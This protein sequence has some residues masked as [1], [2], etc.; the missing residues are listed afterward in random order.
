MHIKN[1]I[2]LFIL[3]FPSFSL[4]FHKISNMKN[5][6]FSS[7]KKRFSHRTLSKVIRFGSELFSPLIPSPSTFHEPKGVNPKDIFSSKEKITPQEPKCVNPKDI[8]PRQQEFNPPSVNTATHEEIQ[9]HNNS[10]PEINIASGSAL[11]INPAG[12]IESVKSPY[13]NLGNAFFDVSSSSGS[14]TNSTLSME[15]KKVAALNN[16]PRK[17]Q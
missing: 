1:S 10:A 4:S 6:S 9:Y 14:S 7:C 5:L 15:T 11:T 2:S 3:F 13:T 16:I 17:I 8:F 12:Y